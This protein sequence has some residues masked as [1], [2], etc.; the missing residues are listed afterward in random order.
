[1]A[2]RRPGRRHAGSHGAVLKFLA[3]A[4]S[5]SRDCLALEAL[6]VTRVSQVQ[7]ALQSRGRKLRVNSRGTERRLFGSQHS[8]RSFGQVDE[9]LYKGCLFSLW[10]PGNNQRV[11]KYHLAPKIVK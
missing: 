10:R 8:W 7:H 6:C 4:A 9:L 3:T 11:M 1:M 5:N 2:T